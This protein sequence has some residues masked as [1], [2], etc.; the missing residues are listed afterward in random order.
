MPKAKTSGESRPRGRRERG[1]KF[2][3]IVGY[4][5][6]EPRGYYVDSVT[7]GDEEKAQF[8]AA[9]AKLDFTNAGGGYRAFFFVPIVEGG[10]DLDS[11][12]KSVYDVWLFSRNMLGKREWEMKLAKYIAG[13]P[14][15]APEA[16]KPDPPGDEWE[17]ICLHRKWMRFD[18]ASE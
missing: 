4:Q 10:R 3:A 17:T 2:W 13:G 9:A 12:K 16:K 1:P 11:K 15:K 5:V 18:S 7:S 14:G 8:E 6:E